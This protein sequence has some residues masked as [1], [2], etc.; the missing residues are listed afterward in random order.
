M[1][2]VR[3]K[4]IT[5]EE[6]ITA[7]LT[8]GMLAFERSVQL[9]EAMLYGRKSDDETVEVMVEVY[10]KGVR[11]QTSNDI[12]PAAAKK[13]NPGK[14]NPQ[15][16]HAA[17]LPSGTD[18]FEIRFTGR[19]MGRAMRP[20]SCD[21]VDVANA[22]AH[23][24]NSYVEAGGFET[25]A[26]LYVWNI[27]NGRFAWRN[28]YMSD[29]AKVV[30]SFDGKTLTFDPFALP[31]D[32]FPGVDALKEAVIDGGVENVE[33]MISNMAKGF[34]GDTFTFSCSWFGDLPPYS[35]VFPSQDYTREEGSP[36][37][38]SLSRIYAYIPTF[39]AGRRIDHASIHSQKIGAALRS[40]DIWHGSEDYGALP[41]NPFTGVQATAEVLRM[42]K[43]GNSFYD[44]RADVSS[45][46]ENL[47]KANGRTDISDKTHFFMANLVRGGVF[48]AAK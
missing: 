48:S 14:S 7:G 12:S 30:V 20:V 10:E 47:A 37:T 42:P 36:K 35:E 22:Y 5:T 23:I 39:A 26:E 24:A 43:S 28:R 34:A 2:F 38:K 29:V 44:I 32:Q 15:V 27:A 25:L 4:I 40:V 21:N 17:V 9:S 16:V 1:T 19:V 11:G 41:V 18:Q 3:N 33:A 46:V 6:A 31:L 13:N 8:T 45:L